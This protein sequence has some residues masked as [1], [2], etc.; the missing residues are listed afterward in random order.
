M[1]LRRILHRRGTLTLTPKR[2]PHLNFCIDLG[3]RFRNRRQE[4]ANAFLLKSVR[5]RESKRIRQK[6][7]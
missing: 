6:V 5:I 7:Y 4:P 1:L 2:V 3:V